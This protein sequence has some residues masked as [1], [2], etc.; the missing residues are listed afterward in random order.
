V[1]S[2][3]I[4]A[5][6]IVPLKA[7]AEGWI[8]HSNEECQP[9]GLVSAKAAGPRMSDTVHINPATVPVE[10][11]YGIQAISYKG[12]YDFALTK[13]LGRV[14]AAVSPSNNEGTFF[15]PP[16]FELPEDLL[17]RHLAQEK[18]KA[19]KMTLA[20]AFN[21]YE[22]RTRLLGRATLNVGAMLKYN[23]DTH[24]ATAGAGISGTA[25]F[26]TFGYSVYS[27][28]SQLDYARYYLRTDKPVISY[29]VETYSLG[30][31]LQSFVLDYSVL[32]LIENEVTTITALTGSLLLSR[33]ILTAA[34]R[35]QQATQAVY[36]P[37]TQSLQNRDSNQNLFL[38][39]QFRLNRFL[40]LG[41]YY[42]YY[43]VRDLSAGATL[44]F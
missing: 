30:F 39:A 32:R 10:N 18:Y 6:I 20:G 38:G 2:L 33:F 26:L 22:G 15:G 11:V 21:A 4:I 17:A 8:C 7:H 41:A 40:M 36:D 34:V 19:N 9:R 43:L 28:Q 3:V 1:K 42:N 16:S 29:L 13:G 23:Q 14:G 35:N 25:S 5:A 24:G 27:D 12:G 31:F 44:L 37:A